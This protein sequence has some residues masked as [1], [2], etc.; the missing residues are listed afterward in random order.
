MLRPCGGIFCSIA[1]RTFVVE[2]TA[3]AVAAAAAAAAAAVASTR[4]VLA[5]RS[6]RSALSGALMM[7]FISFTGTRKVCWLLVYTDDS[8]RVTTA[9]ILDR[10]GE[11]AGTG[12]PRRLLL[13]LLL[14][15]RQRLPGQVLVNGHMLLPPILQS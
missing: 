13:L 3:A 1:S 4:A 10:R 9:G 6:I 5:R 12:G 14:P 15:L 2:S 8:R 11:P 7:G